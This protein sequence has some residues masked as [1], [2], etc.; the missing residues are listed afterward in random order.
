M[1]LTQRDFKLFNMLFDYGLLTTGQMNNLI[2]NSIRKTTILRRL[3]LLEAKGFIKRMIG[4]ES[5]E[6][7]WFLTNEGAFKIGKT[8]LKSHWNR[9]FIPHD[10][11]LIK[12]RLH[13]ENNLNISKWIPEQ[14]LRSLTYKKYGL[15]NAKDK[16]IPD[17]IMILQ[18]QRKNYVVSIELELTQKNKTKLR[19]TLIQY[20]DK[21]E[22]EVI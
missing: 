18:G 8:L 9:N 6:A 13:L 1:L 4:L 3:R 17:G 12:L 11:E 20:Q 15:K 7:L 22:L 19:H 5:F 16:I 21:K 10:H 14:E 2:F